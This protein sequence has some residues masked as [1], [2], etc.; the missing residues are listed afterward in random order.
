MARHRVG[1]G[2][3]I[4]Y[5][6]I[7]T[8]V[9]SGSSTLPTLKVSFFSALEVAQNVPKIMTGYVFAKTLKCV[10]KYLFFDFT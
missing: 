4:Y 5:K 3:Q 6:I 1:G 9:T 2:K 10:N 8:A 7:I